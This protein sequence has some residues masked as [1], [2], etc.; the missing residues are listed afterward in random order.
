MSAAR[1]SDNPLAVA[2]L[3][4]GGA[5]ALL[6]AASGEAVTAAGAAAKV[7]AAATESPDSSSQPTSAKLRRVL[8]LAAANYRPTGLSCMRGAAFS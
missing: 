7:A 8:V 2:D 5:E 1:W 3:G 4:R 6:K